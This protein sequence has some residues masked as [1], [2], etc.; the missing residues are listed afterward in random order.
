[1]R[2]GARIALECPN[3]LPLVLADRIM[4]E[5]VLLNLVRNGLEAM[6]KTP[7]ALRRLTLV[8]V[9]APDAG[10]VQISVADRGHGISEESRARLFEPFY[11][12]K[13]EGMGMGL[14]ICRSIVELHQGRLW[15]EANTPSGSVFQLTLPVA[16]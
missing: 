13:A 7:V 9:P 3:T 5:Q 2:R 6:E 1:V 4:I 10:F 16:P 11:T 8:A 15:V 14:N 12:T